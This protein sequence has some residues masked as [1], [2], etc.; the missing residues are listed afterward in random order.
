MEFEILERMEI[1]NDRVY[2][3]GIRSYGDSQPGRRFDSAEREELSD[4]LKEHGRFAVFNVLG[5]EIFSGKIRIH[6]K[7]P[8]LTTYL[9]RAADLLN[10]PIRYSIDA[11]HAGIFTAEVVE[12]LLNDS[13]YQPKNALQKLEKLREDPEVVFSICKN[14]PSAFSFAAESIR[15]NRLL[16]LRYIEEFV[17]D[18]RFNFPGYFRNDIRIATVALH[19]NGAIFSQLGSSLRN[20]KD[21]VRLAYDPNLPRN[22][23]AVNAADIGK[24]LLFDHKFM[25]GIIRMCPCLDISNCVELLGD[26]SVAETWILNSHWTMQ[27]RY[28][29]PK[30]VLAKSKVRKALY[31]RAGDAPALKEMVDA[32]LF[33]NRVT[34]DAETTEEEPRNTFPASRRLKDSKERKTD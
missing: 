3:S 15:R 28:L 10:A 7:D 21:I 18:P 19:Q 31:T 30:H 5:Q 27:D 13:F 24:S 33:I 22:A 1:R 12:G 29:L 23:Y 34:E 9:K 25:Q 20:N 6:P 26:A 32:L 16:A 14:N 11:E 8:V 4:L 17:L 2:L